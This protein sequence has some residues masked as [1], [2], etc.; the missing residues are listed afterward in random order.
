MHEPLV[1]LVDENDEQTGTAGKLFAHKKAQ[2]HR[3]VSVFVINSRGEWLIQKRAL[4]KY[5]SKGLWTNTCCTHPYPGESAAI[6]ALRRLVEEMGMTCDLDYLF[7]FI[8]REKLDSKLTEHEL[9]HVF[10]GRSDELPKINRK[11]VEDW[12]YISFDD[13]HNDILISRTAYTYWFREI[14]E[15]VNDHII[16]KD[17]RWSL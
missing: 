1:I 11:E 7:S 14:Y 9:D 6:A 17:Y 3:A 10:L 4:D 2:L 16:K 5:H 15:K 8:Y 13:L 12:K